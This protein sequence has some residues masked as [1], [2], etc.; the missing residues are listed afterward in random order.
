MIVIVLFLLLLGLVIPP[1]VWLFDVGDAVRRT[2]LRRGAMVIIFLLACIVSAMIL[3]A[4]VLKGRDILLL[5]SAFWIALLLSF[6]IV[7]MHRHRE[8]VS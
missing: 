7:V 3:M 6:C 5:E 1:L 4:G 8:R 2:G